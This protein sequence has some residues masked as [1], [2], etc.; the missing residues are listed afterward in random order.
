MRPETITIS[1]IN[2]EEN[3]EVQRVMIE[4]YVRFAELYL[5][6]Q[7][8]GQHLDGGSLGVTSA[9]RRRVKYG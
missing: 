3:A 2:S 4:R 8:R 7:K 1:D 9:E 6:L 5:F